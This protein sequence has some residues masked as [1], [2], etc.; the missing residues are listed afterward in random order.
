MTLVQNRINNTFHVMMTGNNAIN[1]KVR[2]KNLKGTIGENLQSSNTLLLSVET[3]I[4][5]YRH[6]HS[7]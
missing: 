1:M 2:R 6:L 4:T 7:L 3:D 5:S